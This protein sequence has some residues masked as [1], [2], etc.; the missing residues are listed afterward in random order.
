MR[1]GQ[2]LGNLMFFKGD[3]YAQNAFNITAYP[4]LPGRI[5]EMRKKA[6]ADGAAAED[7][8]TLG[9]LYL[10]DGQLTNAIEAFQKALDKKPTGDLRESA[11]QKL[12]ESITQIL[13][14]DFAAGKKYL[15]EY[16]AL[17][18]VTPPEGADPAQKQ[19]AADE[20]LKRQEQLLPS[21]S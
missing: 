19:R 10:D 18:E 3:V 17:C 20:S 7:L 16:K 11:R 6:E 1:K 2:S 13:Q 15:E 5:A 14:Q 9:R 12:F 4:D 8:V 21:L